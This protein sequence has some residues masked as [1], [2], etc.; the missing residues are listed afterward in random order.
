MEP[1]VVVVMTLGIMFMGWA[2]YAFGYRD[3]L[4]DGKR[5]R[6]KL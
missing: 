6:R 2:G 5:G 1:V 3:G 4:K